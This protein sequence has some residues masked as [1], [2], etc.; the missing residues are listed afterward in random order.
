VCDGRDL[1]MGRR[2]I[3]FPC[4]TGLPVFFGGDDPLVRSETDRRVRL[5][6]P[7][8]AA[9]AANAL[10]ELGRAFQQA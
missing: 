6:L 4:T 7:R 8:P 3:P 10:S 5:R 2:G 1:G 9:P